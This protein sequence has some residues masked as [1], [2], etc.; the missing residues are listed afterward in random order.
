MKATGLMKIK[1]A[2]PSSALFISAATTHSGS[3][4][5]N[6][7]YDSKYNFDFNPKLPI[8]NPFSACQK[9]IDKM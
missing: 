5:S 1:A 2:N 7:I 6:S 8:T 9:A 4:K 3:S